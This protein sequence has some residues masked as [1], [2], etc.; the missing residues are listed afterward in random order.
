MRIRRLAVF[1][2]VLAIGVRTAAVASS[3]PSDVT[4][5]PAQQGS[6]GATPPGPSGAIGVG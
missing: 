6:A 3:G 5:D 2:L 4:G 1:V